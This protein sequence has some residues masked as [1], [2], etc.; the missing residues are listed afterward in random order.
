MEKISFIFHFHSIS[1][2]VYYQE[3]LHCC[4]KQEGQCGRVSRLIFIEAKNCV[5]CLHSPSSWLKFVTTQ[6][7]QC[8]AHIEHLE[9]KENFKFSLLI[10]YCCCC[11]WKKWKRVVISDDDNNWASPLFSLSL[12]NFYVEH[13]F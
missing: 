7:G 3:R 12:F 8:A 9:A 10:Y 1:H 6:Y 13:V 11:G 4:I 5:S 2:I